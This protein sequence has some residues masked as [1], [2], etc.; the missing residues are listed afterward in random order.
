MTWPKIELNSEAAQIIA[1]LAL[2]T[3]AFGTCHKV[4]AVIGKFL[5]DQNRK[6][7]PSATTTKREALEGSTNTMLESDLLPFDAVRP[8]A[9]LCLVPLIASIVIML[10]QLFSSEPVTRPA[11]LLIT[12]SVGMMFFSL[13]LYFSTWVLSYLYC[14]I[15]GYSRINSRLI[16]DVALRNQKSTDKEE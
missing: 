1:S 10:I 13:W 3:F 5:A 14:A 2:L 11:I 9:K 12:L 16:I 6:K 4:I 15:A 7:S 8:P